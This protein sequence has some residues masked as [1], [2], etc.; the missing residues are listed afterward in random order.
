MIKKLWRNFF[1]LNDKDRAIMAGLKEIGF[2]KLLK[3]YLFFNLKFVIPFSLIIA[4]IRIV[5]NECNLSWLNSDVIFYFF[6][7]IAVSTFLKKIIKKGK[8][9]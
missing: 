7:A 8:Q 6:I 9:K 3:D 1:S 4:T 2:K 5:A